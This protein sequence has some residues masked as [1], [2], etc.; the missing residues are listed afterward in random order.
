MLLLACLAGCEPHEKAANTPDEA[1]VD[2]IEDKLVAT[3]CVGSLN[4]WYRSYWFARD[5]SGS[6]DRNTVAID[7]RQAGF[8]EFGHGRH[9][10]DARPTREFDVDDRDYWIASGSFDVANGRLTLRFC[11]PNMG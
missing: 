2:R 8:D 11:G 10:L 9:R 3:E 1:L 7:L 4:R 6:I 5:R